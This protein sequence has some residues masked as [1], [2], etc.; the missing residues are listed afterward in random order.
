MGSPSTFPASTASFYSNTFNFD[1]LL[2]DECLSMSALIASGQGTLKRGQILCGWNAGSARQSTLST[3]GQAAC[4]IL[5]QDIDTGTG[6]PVEGVVYTQGKFL[7]TAVIA[8]D[9]GLQSDAGQLWN[10]GVYLVTV[11]QRSGL[12]VPWRS[13]PATPDAPLPQET[14]D[15][16]ANSAAPAAPPAAAP[17]P[18]VAHKPPAKG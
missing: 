3:S 15:P 10:S 8:S 4:V 18:P 2:A 12:L 13:F 7:V 14:A 11:E 16:P 6:G 17:T 9:N 1:P 5:A